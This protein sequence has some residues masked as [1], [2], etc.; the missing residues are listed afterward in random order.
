MNLYIIIAFKEI[1]IL[2]VCGK[3][4]NCRVCVTDRYLELF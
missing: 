3:K 1:R 4:S 2:E